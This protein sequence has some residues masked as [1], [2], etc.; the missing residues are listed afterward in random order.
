MTT[1]TPSVQSF[2]GNNQESYADRLQG[3]R[4]SEVGHLDPWKETDMRTKV[5]QRQTKY[6]GSWLLLFFSDCILGLN[7][8]CQSDKAF[9]FGVHQI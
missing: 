4:L 9:L 7:D 5:C 8:S 6:I 3:P 2:I 1:M